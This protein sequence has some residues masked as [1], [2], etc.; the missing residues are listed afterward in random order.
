VAVVRG[1][2]SAEWSIT[3]LMKHTV[4]LG[5]ALIFGGSVG[6]AQASGDSAKA[7]PNDSLAR[8]KTDPAL[9]GTQDSAAAQPGPQ[10]PTQASAIPAPV[11]APVDSIVAA[12]CHEAPPGK[13]APGL[14]TVVFRPGTPDTARVAAAREVSGTL[15][16]TTASGEEYVRLSPESGPLAV[17]AARLIRLPP[18]TSVSEKSCP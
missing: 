16:G 9:G 7:Q 1:G 3:P 18:V 4:L 10:Q 12:A 8:A 14:L 5:A 13:P 2:A 15:A 11:A 6:H 17:A